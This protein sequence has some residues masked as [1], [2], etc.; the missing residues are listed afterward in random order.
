MNYTE[1]VLKEAVM[2]GYDQGY[3]DGQKS[4]KKIV[5]AAFT[6]WEDA[7]EKAKLDVKKG[8]DDG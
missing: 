2:N 1:K 6:I 3:K 8:S 7:E 4:M 5:L